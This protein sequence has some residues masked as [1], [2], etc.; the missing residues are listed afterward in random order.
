MRSPTGRS[1]G[2]RSPGAESGT[3]TSVHARARRRAT[4]CCKR[5]VA[6]VSTGV[7]GMAPSEEGD[8]GEGVVG[9]DVDDLVCAEGAEG[10]VGEEA[11]AP[12]VDGQRERADGA[13]AEVEE[14]ALLDGVV[15]IDGVPAT[16]RVR[17]DVA[18]PS[19]EPTEPPV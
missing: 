3:R 10:A 11:G 2:T 7:S 17:T 18:R 5:R 1:T 12:D 16:E 19:R 14:A 4:S 15:G 9:G 8:A 6:G 13:G